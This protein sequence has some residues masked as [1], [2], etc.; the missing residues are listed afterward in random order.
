MKNE[1]P[2]LT[3]TVSI[4]YIDAELRTAKL[5]ETGTYPNGNPK[6]RTARIYLPESF[7]GHRVLCL[8]LPDDAPA[9]INATTDAESSKDATTN[10]PDPKK[11]QRKNIEEN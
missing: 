11:K 3:G 8:L 9:T 2:N 6:P 5:I 10:Q 4:P 1:K 7:A